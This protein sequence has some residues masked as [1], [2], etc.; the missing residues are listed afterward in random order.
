MKRVHILNIF[1]DRMVLSPGTI[2]C[3][4]DTA[5]LFADASKTERDFGWSLKIDFNELDNHM[6]DA[7]LEKHSLKSPGKGTTILLSKDIQWR[8]NNQMCTLKM[9]EV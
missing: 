3:A 5:F 6:V 9:N 2:R 7:D 8:N 4:C 1:G